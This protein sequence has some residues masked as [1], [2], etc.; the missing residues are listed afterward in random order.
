MFDRMKEML[1]E[2]GDAHYDTAQP[3]GFAVKGRCWFGP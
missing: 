1:I 2:M 3:D